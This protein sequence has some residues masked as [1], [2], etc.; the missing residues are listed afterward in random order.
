MNLV[1]IGPPGAGKGT[2]AARVA[3]VWGVP[4]ISTGD[5]LRRALDAGD[6]LGAS[7]GLAMTRG[8]LVSDGIMGELVSN[9]LTHADA[10]RGFVL[11]G[12]PRTLEQAFA[13]DALLKE[14]G[15]LAVVELAVPDSELL[16][17]LSQRR[18]CGRCGANAESSANDHQAECGCGGPLVLRP[19]DDDGVARERL[20]V[21][22]KATAPVIEFYRE[23]R[24]LRTINGN[25]PTDQVT[26][27][28]NL[29]IDPIFDTYF[30]SLPNAWSG[31]TPFLTS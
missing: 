2:Q 8:E 3:L 23:R 29:A 16:R 27:R 17:R 26:E 19:D 18:V 20:A 21:Y 10:S 1:L 28:I 11:D 13:L 4:R 30:D 5:I 9:S 6:S 31:G 7:V 25:L 14:R 24:A 12:F 22:A 15:R